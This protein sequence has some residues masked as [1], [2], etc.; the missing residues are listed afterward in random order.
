MQPGQQNVKF[1]SKIST[2]LVF[3]TILQMKI[4]HGYFRSFQRK[5]SIWM[6]NDKFSDN[7]CT[8]NCREIQTPEH[9][10]LHCQNY[11]TQINE[12]KNSLNSPVNFQIL[13]NTKNGLKNL[14]KFLQLTKIATRKW[15]LGL[16]EIE[17]DE[18]GWGDLGSEFGPETD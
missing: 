3:S 8:G 7:L 14:V 16:E 13:M 6:N 17:I 11:G 2:K 18:R 5:L 1:L 12:L 4:G 9:L 10:I 15:L